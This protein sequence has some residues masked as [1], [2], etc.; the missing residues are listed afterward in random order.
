MHRFGLFLAQGTHVASSPNLSKFVIYRA[1]SRAV[2]ADAEEL[3]RNLKV[4]QAF[5]HFPGRER[6]RL[7][8]NCGPANHR[9]SPWLVALITVSECLLIM[10][11]RQCPQ[12]RCQ[13]ALLIR[14]SLGQQAGAL[15]GALSTGL[16]NKAPFGCLT[17]KAPCKAMHWCLTDRALV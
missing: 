1:K 12:V 4:Y 8:V 15:A 7:K 17:A 3:F 9:Q 2:G 5:A 13:G 14:W 10:A 6:H 16:G 11:S